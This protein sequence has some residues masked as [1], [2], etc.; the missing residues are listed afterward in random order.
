MILNN[1]IPRLTEAINKTILTSRKQKV[2]FIYNELLTGDTIN[3]VFN[4]IFR[5][6]YDFTTNHDEYRFE[7]TILPKQQ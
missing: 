4:W 2:K 1:A 5:K 6:G 7:I 3:S